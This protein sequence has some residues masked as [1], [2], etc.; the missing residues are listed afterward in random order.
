MS[1]IEVFIYCG[2]YVGVSL[3]SLCESS[4][5]DKRFVFSID[6]CHILSQCVWTI[7][8]LMGMGLLLRQPESALIV[9][10][11]LFFVLWLSLPCQNMV[12]A[13]KAVVGLNALKPISEL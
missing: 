2:P 12:C 6:A 13:I 8:P 11:G 5:F 1:L 7:I 4:I 9:E 10:L 3:Y